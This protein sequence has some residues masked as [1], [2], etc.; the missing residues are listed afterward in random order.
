[1]F[2]LR[3]PPTVVR[4]AW[5]VDS[6]N[7]GR[8]LPTASY[9]VDGV[10]VQKSTLAASFAAAAS[11]TSAQ[12]LGIGGKAGDSGRERTDDQPR[13]D[14]DGAGVQPPRWVL[15]DR[16]K[17]GVDGRAETGSVSADGRSADK[18]SANS[19][20]GKMPSMAVK[21][22]VAEDPSSAPRGR[23]SANHQT[24]APPILESGEGAVSA[25]S[26]ELAQA[27]GLEGRRSSSP[28]ERPLENPWGEQPAEREVG[29]VDAGGAESVV[30]PERVDDGVPVPPWMQCADVTDPSERS[31]SAG[32]DPT[33]MKTFFQ[34][35]RLH[36]I[37]VG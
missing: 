36:Y 28:G 3:H 13:N 25:A 12:G 2:Q 23:A 27:S 17:V 7:A 4:S 35:S 18:A 31:R 20:G 29:G 33:F 16:S 5:I 22:P 32:N 1:M 6:I 30:A 37:G 24:P 11:H 19:S 10:L 21:S 26:G 8:K 15:P 34:A 14:G 9:M